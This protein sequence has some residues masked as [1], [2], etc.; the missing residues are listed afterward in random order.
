M[1]RLLSVEFRRFFARRLTRWACVALLLGIAAIGIGTFAT[2]SNDVAA[3]HR[4]A[5]RQAARF[6]QEQQQARQQCVASVPADQVD[7]NCGTDEQIPTAENFYSDPRFSFHDHVRDL[8]GTGC[9]IGSLLGLILAA[10]LIGAEWQAGTFA[11]LL[12]WEPR[13]LRVAAA[14]VAAVIVGSLA[15]ATVATA[16][17][18][19]VE[20]VVAAT[21]GTFASVLRDAPRQ[22]H[23]AEQTWALAGRAALVVMLVSGM[24]AALALLLRHTVAALGVAIGYLIV[25]EGIIGSLRHGDVRH[26][27]LQSRL[28]AL[29]HGR[30]EWPI[31]IRQPD[32]SI[33]FGPDHMAVVH[34]LNAGIEALVVLAVLFAI[35]LTI[36]Q[37]RDVT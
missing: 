18:L 32:G 35:A 11:T 1:S 33:A 13:R 2:T 4:A 30:Y 27:L 31:P 36:L 21:H 23:F 22:P 7:Q 28:D 15:I 3:A 19:G 37:R 34:A 26:H 8:L 29:L 25:G 6:I 10:S 9:V 20:A 16:V 24:G 12:T 17:L 5:A 14:K